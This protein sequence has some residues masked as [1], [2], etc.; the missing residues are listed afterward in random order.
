MGWL[1]SSLKFI[2]ATSILVFPLAL[3][4]ATASENSLLL[5]VTHVRA[6]RLFQ[7]NSTNWSG[8]ASLTSLTSPDRDSVSFVA[9]DWTIP[10]L[11][12][13][14]LTTYS[15]A[16][17][18]IDGYSDN[19]VEQI[20]TEHDCYRGQSY[21]S[22]WYEMYPRS[23]RTVRLPV[24][25]GDQIHAEV[26]YTN[27]NRFNLKIQ[28]LSTGRSY[29]TTQKAGA[30]RTSAEWVVEAPS[31]YFGVLPLTNFGTITMS[32]ASA[33]ING[34]SGAID[35]WPNDPIDMVNYS[36]QLKA[37]TGPLDSSGTSFDVT[38]YSN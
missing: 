38:W 31:S 8:Y 34:V 32:N 19:T 2:L 20:G 16:W 35:N 33:T 14:S 36:N 6:H 21:Y 3:P 26:S 27:R 7:S 15:S 30:Q 13:T 5:P 28:N 37:K 11:T 12:C 1:K 18:G 17:V 9:G 29:T 25:A 22:V 10:S 4:I 23:M 24:K